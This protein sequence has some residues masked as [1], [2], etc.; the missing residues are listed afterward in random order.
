MREHRGDSGGEYQLNQEAWIEL[1]NWIY[2]QGYE[3][4][5]TPDREDCLFELRER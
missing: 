1:S 5:L 2:K 4:R 3:V